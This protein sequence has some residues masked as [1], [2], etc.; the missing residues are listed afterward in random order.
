M[1][2]HPRLDLP[3]FALVIIA[4]SLWASPDLQAQ[5]KLDIRKADIDIGTIYNGAIIRTPITISNAGT[6][7]LTIKSVRTS[8]GCTTVKQ[9]SEA[10]KPGAS[11]TIEVE[12]NSAGFRGRAVKYVYIQTNDPGSDYHT[13]TLRVDIKEELVPVP[14]V[15]VIWLGNVPVGKAQSKTMIFANASGAKLTVKKVSSLPSSVKAT[16]RPK[17]LAPSDTLEIVLTITP[18]QEGYV[19]AEVFVETTSTK[20]PRVPFRITYIGVKPE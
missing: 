20:Q 5:P 3:A 4:L 2:S 15:S 14:P 19:N 10:L 8:C 9:P 13:I 12:F 17:T 18:D 1:T 7:E 16:I 6:E 11:A